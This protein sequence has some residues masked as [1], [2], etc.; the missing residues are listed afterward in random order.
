M[1]L[2]TLLAISALCVPSFVVFSPEKAHALP[3]RYDCASMQEYA[4]SIKWT[5]PTRFSGFQNLSI[6]QQSDISSCMGGYAKETSPMGTRVCTAVLS[7]N[8]GGGVYSSSGYKRGMTW[9]PYQ[10]NSS[11]CRWI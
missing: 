8:A 4:N 5:N 11:N 2:K 10:A 9:V 7:Y 3:F 1:K 6:Q